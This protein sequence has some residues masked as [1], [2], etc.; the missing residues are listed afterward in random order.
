MASAA[1]STTKT[2]RSLTTGPARR[3]RTRPRPRATTF[4]RCSDV[5]A[6]LPRL[7][8]RAGFP[9]DGNGLV[10]DPVAGAVFLH[11]LGAGPAAPPGVGG[12]LAPIRRRAA[13][14]RR[15]L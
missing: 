14:T 1:A 10:L 2:G 11:L 3:R 15:C 12:Y 7:A 5:T 6:G 4:T 9:G 13:V 8:G